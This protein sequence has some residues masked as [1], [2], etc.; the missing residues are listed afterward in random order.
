MRQCQC[1]FI[2]PAI[3]PSLYSIIIGAAR[4][5]S[6]FLSHFYSS[7]FFLFLHFWS[8]KVDALWENAHHTHTR[9]LSSFPLW[10]SCTIFHHFT[11]LLFD[12]HKESEKKNQIMNKLCAHSVLLSV[13]SD[14]CIFVQY[15][16]DYAV[17]TH[18]MCGC[19]LYENADAF[20]IENWKIQQKMSVDRI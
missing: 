15:H 2:G 7:H 8:E 1:R 18:E 14:G 12:F 5:E 13:G 19:F 11:F 16:V 3:A 4:V 6:A 10:L 9:I 17:H 20:W